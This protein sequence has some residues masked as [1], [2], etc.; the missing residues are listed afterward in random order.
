MEL[1]FLTNNYC[2]NVVVFAQYDGDHA[3]YFSN[4]EFWIVEYWDS[5][6]DLKKG[7]TLENVYYEFIQQFRIEKEYIFLKAKE[8]WETGQEDA[9]RFNLPTFYVDFDRH[10][11]LSRFS[12]QLFERR[13]ISTW[14]GEFIDFLPRIPDEFRYWEFPDRT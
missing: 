12:E 14:K 5:Y 4:K 8:L 7:E 11:F 10:I 1:D 6:V 13:M 3:Y 9:I 2:E